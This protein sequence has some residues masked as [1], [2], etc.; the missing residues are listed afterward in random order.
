[1]ISNIIITI[2][3]VHLLHLIIA[4]FGMDS[5][6]KSNKYYNH[7]TLHGGKMKCFLQKLHFRM[8]KIHYSILWR[9]KLHYS[10]DQRIKKM[11]RKSICLQLLLCSNFRFLKLYCIK[12]WILLQEVRTRIGLLPRNKSFQSVYPILFEKF[13]H[14]PG[15]LSS[16]S[17]KISYDCCITSTNSI[18][19]ST[20][21][22]LNII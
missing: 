10:D 19:D 14:C 16:V 1:M 8:F 9:E 11:N 6:Y 12:T 20:F 7:Q 17:R 2:L 3:R 21:I 4:S 13:N 5:L 22:V 18:R 15:H